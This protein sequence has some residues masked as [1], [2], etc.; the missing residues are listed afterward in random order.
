MPDFTW[1]VQDEIGAMPRPGP[2]TADFEFLKDNGIEALVS[3]TETA[4]RKSLV[5]EFGFEYLHVPVNDFT[6][7]SLEQV[8]KF[9]AFVKRMR[10]AKKKVAVHC[11][12][13]LGRTGT[14][15]SCYLVSKGYTAQDSIARVRKVRP[16]SVETREQEALVKDYERRL[17]GR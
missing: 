17:F 14:M 1:L 13:G 16:G 8:E 5:E 12:A 9:V 6:A 4:L 2:G 11:G 3:L 15:L 10:D 7:P